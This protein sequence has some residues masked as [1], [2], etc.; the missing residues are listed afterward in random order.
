MDSDLLYDEFGNY[1]GPEL[2]SD[3]SE[4]SGDSDDSGSESGRRNL[5][6]EDDEM[7]DEDGDDDDRA[8]ETNNATA[9][10]LHE[11]KKYYPTA[12]E[13]YGPDVET[14]V[15]VSSRTEQFYFK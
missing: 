5:Q 3:D 9:I 10:V 4:G 13:V 12:L 6:D 7:G 15:Q 8:D 2:A 11:D 1:I 14:L